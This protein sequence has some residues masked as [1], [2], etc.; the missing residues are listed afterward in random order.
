VSEF[1]PYLVGFLLGLAAPTVL[2]AQR[3]TKVETQVTAIL[4]TLRRLAEAGAHND[5]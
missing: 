3:L 5:A 2:F 1:A 4:E